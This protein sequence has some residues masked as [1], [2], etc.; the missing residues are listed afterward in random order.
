MSIGMSGAMRTG[1]VSGKAAAKWKKPAV[2]NATRVQK[3]K[4]ADFDGKRRDEGGRG[5]GPSVE[6]KGQI[7]RPEMQ[8]DR[9]SSMPS[10]KTGGAGFGS[11]TRG[12]KS[13]Q[14]GAVGSSY[15]PGRKAI[16]QFPQKQKSTFP[17]GAG[18]SGK[19]SAKTGNTRMKHSVPRSGGPY[20][21]GGKG[22]Q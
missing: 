7:D 19:P 22:T 3:S 13:P 21:G 1:L 18:Y 5:N 4:M 10:T 15:V 8:R 17:K 20:G 2:L 9:V 12:S 16:D 6:V 11:L 14:G